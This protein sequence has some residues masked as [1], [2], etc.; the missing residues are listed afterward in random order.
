MIPHFLYLSSLTHISTHSPE[1][2]TIAEDF[3]H[4]TYPHYAYMTPASCTRTPA[5]ITASW[6]RHVQRSVGHRM[7]AGGTNPLGWCSVI[8]GVCG[9]NSVELFR[10]NNIKSF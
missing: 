1:G 6:S 3:P 2:A 10:R 7:T 5:G 4:Y 9:R 8:G